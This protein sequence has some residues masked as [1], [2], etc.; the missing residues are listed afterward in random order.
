MKFNK[1]AKHNSIEID[2]EGVKPSEKVRELMKAYGFWWFGT[3]KVWCHTLAVDG[4]FFEKFIEERIAPLAAAPS[5]VDG[6]VAAAKGMSDAD[7]QAVLA[8]L[9]NK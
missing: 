8:A 7:R 3:G 2:F 9:M 1:N 4:D 5:T 6:I